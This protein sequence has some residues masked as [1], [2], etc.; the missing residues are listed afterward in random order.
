MKKKYPF[1]LNNKFY[2][3]KKENFSIG[4]KDV[5]L[6]YLY[7]IFNRKYLYESR[8]NNNAVSLDLAYNYFFLKNNLQAM[9]DIV[10]MPLGHASVLI[11]YKNKAILFDPLFN[12]SSL[13]FKRYVE[14]IDINYLPQ[15]D[16]I[17]FS[18][19]HPDHYNKNDLLM[20]LDHSPGVHIIAPSGFNSFLQKEG[21]NSESIRSMTW[22]EEVELFGGMIKFSALPAVHWSQSNIMNKNETLWAS[23]MIT[24]DSTNI[25]FAGDTAYGDHF[26]SIK[27]TFGNVDIACMPIAPYAPTELQIDVHINAEES[28]QAFLDLGQ[29]IFIPIHWGVFAY[30]DEPLKEP[31]E[32]IIALFYDNNFMHKLKS[33]II[34]VPYV[35]KK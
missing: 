20:L 13:F 35:Y 6:N 29:P 16:V 12:K 21:I 19:N 9:G 24:I 33:T 32:K 14:N 11:I 23:W 5:V 34:N 27:E 1:Y 17:V 2:N 3:S 10:V 15:I 25:Y 22:W 31:I 26:K 7:N 28:F 30:G 8:K 4:L 18:H